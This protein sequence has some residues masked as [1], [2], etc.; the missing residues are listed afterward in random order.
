VAEFDQAHPS[1]V[2]VEELALINQLE[3]PQAVM[4][5]NFQAKRVVGQ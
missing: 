5:V 1:A 2:P 3:G 4:P